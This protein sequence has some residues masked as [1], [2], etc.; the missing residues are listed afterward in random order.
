MENKMVKVGNTKAR[1]LGRSL[2]LFSRP[3]RKCRK[4]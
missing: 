2:R 1:K 3:C 4:N